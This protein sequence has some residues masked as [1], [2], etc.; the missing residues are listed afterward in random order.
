MQRRRFLQ[1]LAGATAA[2]EIAPELDAADR[3]EP[4]AGHTVQGEFRLGSDSWKVY[5]D[6]T[7]RDGSITFVSLQGVRRT[8]EKSAEATF[9]EAEPPYL[10]LKLADVGTAGEDLLANKLLE[11]GDPDP[12]Q[13]RS[14]APPM[15]SASLNPDVRPRWN[16]FVGT[17]ECSDTMPVFP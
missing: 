6:L 8:L 13:V 14:A 5:E 2:I 15:G 1:Q 11:N 16:T 10:G 17:V 3:Q 7:T 4:L 12:K 9:A